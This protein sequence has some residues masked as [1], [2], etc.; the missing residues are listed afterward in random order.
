MKCAGRGVG[1]KTVKCAGMGVGL[2]VAVVS[3][4]WVIIGVPKI[5]ALGIYP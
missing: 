2:V 4:Y 3:T 5:I 1:F